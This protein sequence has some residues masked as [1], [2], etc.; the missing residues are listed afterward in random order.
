MRLN[1]RKNRGS[2]SR[3]KRVSDDVPE[4][5]PGGVE[6]REEQPR[7]SLARSV[8]KVRSE[9]DAQFEERTAREER[10]ARRAARK[11]RK[12]RQGSKDAE[13]SKERG[14]RKRPRIRIRGTREERRPRERPHGESAAGG[15]AKLVRAAKG[16]AVDVLG[17][18]R[19]ILRWPARIW[20]A[21]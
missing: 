3:P 7:S 1:R 2:E 6:E 9:K 14:T 11:S 17:I 18:A 16:V 5:P 19:E 10:E 21:V 13:D 12:E 20:M 4:S 8:R 15:R